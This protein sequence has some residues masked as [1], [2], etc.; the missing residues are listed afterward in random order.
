M[1]VKSAIASAEEIIASPSEVQVEPEVQPDIQPVAL[2]EVNEEI[3]LGDEEC[4]SVALNNVTD[5]VTA[6][7]APSGQF[8]NLY[9]ALYGS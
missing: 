3:P 8:S 9:L 7:N 4:S 6:P 5:D 1:E 2:E